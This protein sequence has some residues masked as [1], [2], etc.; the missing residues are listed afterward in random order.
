MPT[1]PYFPPIHL[2]P[3]YR[4]RF[5]YEPG[6][7]PVAEAAARSTIALPFHTSMAQDEVEYVCRQLAVVLEGGVRISRS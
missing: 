7:F 3:F 5:G 2:A 6:D 1:R 4:E